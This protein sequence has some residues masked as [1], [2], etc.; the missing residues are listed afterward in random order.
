MFEV[1]RK[2]GIKNHRTLHIKYCVSLERNM[3]NAWNLFVKKVYHEGKAKDANYD[4]K[5]ALKDASRRKREMG[6]G[7]PLKTAKAKR[8]RSRRSASMAGGRKSRRHRRYR[9]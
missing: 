2:S 5:T 9:R 1:R 8:G 7:H 4:F 3:A 6:S